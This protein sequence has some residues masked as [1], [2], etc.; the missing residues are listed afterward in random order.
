MTMSRSRYLALALVGVVAVPTMIVGWP[1]D[2]RAPTVSDLV[3][4]EDATTCPLISISE[5]VPIVEDVLGVTVD[6]EAVYA[7]TEDDS[8]LGCGFTAVGDPVLGVFV[9]SV[10]PDGL[11]TL[12]GLGA[13][14]DPEVT[15]DER[16]RYERLLET[17]STANDGFAA[18]YT[19]ELVSKIHDRS[20]GTDGCGCGTIPHSHRP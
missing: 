15:T 6:E 16:A 11:A 17:G 18:R 10:D 8:T 1:D 2:S 14:A 3:A 4:G 5:L 9:R 19:E 7:G 12:I 13:A 20:F